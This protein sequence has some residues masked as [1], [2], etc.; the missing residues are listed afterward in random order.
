[1]FLLFSFALFVSA[2]FAAD[3]RSFEDLKTQL[4]SSNDMLFILQNPID[5]AESFELRNDRGRT[6][7]CVQSP[8]FRI[9]GSAASVSFV[10]LRFDLPSAGSVFDINQVADFLVQNMTSTDANFAKEHALINIAGRVGR[11]TIRDVGRPAAAARFANFIGRSGGPIESRVTVERSFIECTRNDRTCVDLQSDATSPLTY[12][13]V[14]SSLAFFASP[15]NDLVVSVGGPARSTVTFTNCNLTGLVTLGSSVEN[16]TVSGGWWRRAAVDAEAVRRVV[17]RDWTVFE[18]RTNREQLLLFRES[19]NASISISNVNATGLETGSLVPRQL[20]SHMFNVAGATIDIRNV[21]AR[22]FDALVQIQGFDV[23]AVTID[24]ARVNG[25][26]VLYHDTSSKKSGEIVVRNI[27]AVGTTAAGW[28]PEIVTVRSESAVTIENVSV[29]RFLRVDQNMFF[30]QAG[31][32]SARFQNVSIE[33]SRAARVLN[34]ERLVDSAAFSLQQFRFRN[35]TVLFQLLS[36]QANVALLDFTL[37]DVKCQQC[38]RRSDTASN[39]T[40]DNL[41]A[42]QLV[43]ERVV[44]GRWSRVAGVRVFDSAVTS[45][46]LWLERQA[47]QRLNVSLSDWELVNVTLSDRLIFL[48]LHD[49]G[50]VAAHRWTLR[51]CALPFDRWMI[52]AHTEVATLPSLDF[53]SL[54]FQNVSANL[55]WASRFAV[56]VENSAFDRFGGRL[57]FGDGPDGT[58]Q[59]TFVMRNVSV[60]QRDLCDN[61]ESQIFRVYR[62]QSVLFDRVTLTDNRACRHALVTVVD[63]GNFTVVHSNFD[64]QSSEFCIFDVISTDFT[65]TNSRFDGNRAR[66]YGTVSFRGDRGSALTMREVFFRNCSSLEG[67][68]IKVADGGESGHRVSIGESRFFDNHATR[69]GGVLFATGRVALNVSGSLFRNNSAAEDGGVLFV[70]GQPVPTVRVERC[71]FEDNWASVRG[72]IARLS[73]VRLTL[74]GVSVRNNTLD[75]RAQGGGS[76]QE[77]G[78]FFASEGGNV[79]AVRD[80]CLCGQVQLLSDGPSD[81]P[82]FRCNFK[83]RGASVTVEGSTTATGLDSCTESAVEVANCTAVTC[84]RQVPALQQNPAT[85]VPS[86]FVP[87]T[88]PPPASAPS[89]ATTAP[90]TQRDGAAN[91]TSIDANSGAVDQ[92]SGA[93][94]PLGGIIGG[95]LGGVGLL[96]CIVAAI[97]FLLRRKKAARAQEAEPS[98]TSNYGSVTELQAMRNKDVNAPVGF[99]SNYDQVPSTTEEFSNKFAIAP[100][101]TLEYVS[102]ASVTQRNTGVVYDAKFVDAPVPSEYGAAAFLKNNG[103][104][105]S[106][107]SAGK[108]KRKKKLVY[109]AGSEID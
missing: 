37:R 105:G 95:A 109:V 69:H 81:A 6:F 84:E 4:V 65:V 96:V 104:N 70:S 107:G 51:H 55:M 48:E 24:T 33:D 64:R 88:L 54:V 74:V 28:P 40:I 58:K 7:K 39:S 1:M 12:I 38:F 75:R 11:I 94:V 90:A 31:A 3:V 50:S 42:N 86:D 103:S 21:E 47:P 79:I 59:G 20:F 23:G 63:S 46:V 29:R 68:A 15:G 56:T 18:G 19:V 5:V 13:F 9:S 52:G 16:L 61:Y 101:P 91:A 35:V 83:D 22:H 30:V 72:P 17:I 100:E 62:A 98:R 66:D 76:T 102:V 77:S 80:S 97:V 44:H 2:V 67:A 60:S 14:D 92:T 26:C 49:G 99:S 106:N 93:T 82:S 8:C 43:A 71:D 85:P 87:I 36:S 25:M 32:G 41:V 78:A 10:D 89:A 53:Q 34:F 27:D 108:K 73:E 45:A 57:V